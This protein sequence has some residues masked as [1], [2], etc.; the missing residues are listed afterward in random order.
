[1][2]KLIGGEPKHL[3]IEDVLHE[4][5]I[6]KTE[7]RTP[8]GKDYSYYDLTITT[9]DADG[10]ELELKAGYPLPRTGEPITSKAMLG[11]VLEKF[12]GKKIV[13]GQEYDLDS[14][15]TGTVKFQTKTV[16]KNEI[17]YTEIIRD[18]LKPA[19]EVE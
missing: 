6:T 14:L 13:A 3:N 1:M 17:N 5:E 2:N 15:I 16:T 10:K 12:I 11:Q 18:T 8:E 9:V 19:T 4:G 7:V